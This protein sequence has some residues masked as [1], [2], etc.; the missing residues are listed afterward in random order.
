MRVIPVLVLIA[1]SACGDDGGGGGGNPDS[2]P[3]IDAPADLALDADPSIAPLVGTWNKAPESWTGQMI[4]I[5]TFRANG[6]VSLG[7]ATGADEGTFTVP[8]PGKLRMVF[9]GS[10]LESDYVLVND[11]LMITAFLPQGTVTGLVGMW[12]NVTTS[13]TTG[14]AV[15]DIRADMTASYI[16]TGPS[17]TGTWDGTWVAEGTGFEFTATTPTALS[18]HFRPIGTA[19]IGTQ[20]FAKQ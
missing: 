8:M 4:T 6:T 11:R 10:T 19:A 5:V 12:R 14:T 18:L 2:G 1:L 17:G 9:P 13:T 20:L 15:M 7:D 16:L 3:H